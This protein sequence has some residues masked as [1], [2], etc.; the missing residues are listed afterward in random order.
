MVTPNETG[1]P[2]VS[3]EEE[4]RARERLYEPAMDRERAERLD[5]GVAEPL[6]DPEPPAS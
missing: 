2:T 6:P 5:D 4:V 3:R 1:D